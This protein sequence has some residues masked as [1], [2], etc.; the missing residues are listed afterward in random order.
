MSKTAKWVLLM[1]VLLSACGAKQSGSSDDP[2]KD[3]DLNVKKVWNAEVKLKVDIAVKQFGGEIGASK[4]EEI[5]TK[6]DN[7]TSDWVMLKESACQDHFKRNIL[8]AEEYKA[9]AACFDAFLQNQRTMIT[10]LEGGD[11]SA[12]DKLLTSSTGLGQCK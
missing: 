7:I 5:T 12:S 6:M 11:Q 8:T 3:F 9:K 10:A 2:C 1:A 4:A